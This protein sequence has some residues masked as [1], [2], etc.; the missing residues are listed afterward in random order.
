MSSTSFKGETI[1]CLSPKL[2][3][4]YAARLRMTSMNAFLRLFGVFW[5]RECKGYDGRSSLITKDEAAPYVICT[6]SCRPG[7]K[8]CLDRI[9]R[10][11]QATGSRRSRPARS[12][13]SASAASQSSRAAPPDRVD[14]HCRRRKYTRRSHRAAS[15]IARLP[16]FVSGLISVA[17]PH[18]LSTRHSASSRSG[19]SR[20]YDGSTTFGATT[21]PL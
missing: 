2:N 17:V 3:L 4:R 11:A 5:K 10:I 8:H 12:P 7:R 6:P 19:N 16:S 14:G 9:R 18:S 13:P 21:E 1:R 20:T 15:G